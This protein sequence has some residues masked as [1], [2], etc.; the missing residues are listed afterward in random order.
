MILNRSQKH[1]V[2]AEENESTLST[3]LQK[4]GE[5]DKVIGCNV[6]ELAPVTDSVVSQFTTAKL[7]YKIIRY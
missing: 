4:V 3:F 1:N 5:N 7:V 6:M 2:S